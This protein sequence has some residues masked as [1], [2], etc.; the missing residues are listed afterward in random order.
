MCCVALETVA[1]PLGHGMWWPAGLLAAVA[2]Q[3]C[4]RSG[5]P[6][7]LASSSSAPVYETDAFHEQGFASSPR[8]YL[9]AMEKN[10]GVYL[11][12]HSPIFLHDGEIK[13]G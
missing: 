11:S 9:A 3:P 7:S 6:E 13:S 5:A 12:V 2:I 10:Q 1:G 8:F 4:V